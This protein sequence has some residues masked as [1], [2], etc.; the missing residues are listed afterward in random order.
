MVTS[1]E[2]TKRN[3]LIISSLSQERPVWGNPLPQTLTFNNPPFCVACRWRVRFPNAGKPQDLAHCSG[4]A[5]QH[6]SSPYKHQQIPAQATPGT[7]YLQGSQEKK[8]TPWSEQRGGNGVSFSPLRKRKLLSRTFY[9]HES[10]EKAEWVDSFPPLKGPF[11]N[12]LETCLS[13]LQGV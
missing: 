10:L 8:G 9:K 13:L 3:E 12:S 4:R 5:G 6:G 1:A 11:H 2:E 7:S